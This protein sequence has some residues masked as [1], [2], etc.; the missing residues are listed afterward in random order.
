MAIFKMKRLLAVLA[1]SAAT[2]SLPSHAM[3]AGPDGKPDQH[4]YVTT[5]DGSTIVSSDFE[6]GPT[7][8]GK[9]GPPVM[10]T[11]ATVTWSLMPTGTSCA[12]ESAGC[13]ITSLADFMPAGF[14]NAITAAFDAWSAVA[15]I[16]FMQVGDDGSAFNSP[17][18]AGDIR[19]GGHAFD[20]AG[21]TLAHG[22]YPPA[23]GV[24]AAGDIHFDIAEIWKLGFGGPGFD[25]FQV[26]AH[27]IGHAIGL[28]HS[29]VPNSLMNP[30]YTEAFSG[31]QADD[32]AGAQ[33]IYGSPQTPVP[34][35]GTL[36]LIAIGLLAS[37][38][39]RR[40]A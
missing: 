31:P 34:A 29:D 5:D 19:L 26:A 15:D 17:G 30:F 14:M 21:G 10:G 3:K 38:L 6:L 36:L 4:N 27:E 9:W 13:T 20:G 25:I 35:P 24:T 40:R 2:F 11:G 23:N 33:F 12:A 37:G 8:P 18:V 1:M 22:Y 28:A 32:I 39:S 7:D 16:V